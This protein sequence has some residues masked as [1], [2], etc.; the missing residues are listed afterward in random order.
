MDDLDEDEARYYPRFFCLDCRTDT[1][2]S[3]EYYMVA[4]NVWAASGLAPNGG[5][6][7]LVCLERRIGR[8]LT[9]EDFAALWPT[10][11]AWE[12]HITARAG[13]ADPP[14]QLEIWQA[15]TKEGLS[16]A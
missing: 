10:A 16:N 8:P 11:S 7:C 15:N 2:E 14:E 5:M 6:L 13:S 4:D 9:S 1:C 12:R 3:G